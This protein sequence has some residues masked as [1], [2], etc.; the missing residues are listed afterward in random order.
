LLACC[1]PES[2]TQQPPTAAPR[3]VTTLF[4]KEKELRELPPPP[5][6][7]ALEAL[8]QKVA[9]Q[10]AAVKEAK[11]VRAGRHVAGGR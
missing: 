10:G 4:N 8:R 11:A 3:Q 2:D 6:K 9:D 7:A 1:K 5:S